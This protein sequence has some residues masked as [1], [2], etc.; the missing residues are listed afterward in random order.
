MERISAIS[1]LPP[2]GSSG[3][4]TVPFRGNFAVHLV[5]FGKNEPDLVEPKCPVPIFF[6]FLLRPVNVMLVFA[7]LC[8]EIVACAV[9][10]AHY[11][12]FVVI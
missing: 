7:R 11:L 3:V 2:L 1:F 9:L 12:L 4:T 5:R 10:L 6:F 8:R